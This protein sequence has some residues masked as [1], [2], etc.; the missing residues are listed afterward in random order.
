MGVRERLAAAGHVLPPPPAVLGVYV[1]AIREGGLVFTA[2]QLPMVDGELLATGSVGA[3]V[4]E[5]SGAACAARCAL[6]ALAAA[7]TVCDLDGPVRVVRLTCYVASARGFRRQAVVADGA[8][9]VLAAAFG[10]AGPHAREA[11]GVA[12]LPL[13]APVEASL[14]LAVG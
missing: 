9:S 10:E 3:D 7:S 12:E 5:E 8:S 1:P 13:G 14:V 2:G 6:N 4:G 11:I